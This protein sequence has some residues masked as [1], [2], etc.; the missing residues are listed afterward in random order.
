MKKLILSVI[1]LIISFW[2]A[3]Y[4]MRIYSADVLYESSQRYLAA[5]E[6][7]DALRTASLAIKKNPLEP[8]YYRG[9]AKVYIGFLADTQNRESQLLFKTA[10]LEDLKKAYKL[11]P[12]NLVTIRNSVPLYYFLAAED[13]TQPGS[14]ENI[15]EAFLSEAANFFEKTKLAFPNDVGVFTLIAKY[16]KRLGLEKQYEESKARVQQLRPDLLEWHENF[17]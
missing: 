9:R 11:N 8:N 1:I 16:E 15:D 14:K 2:S 10:A 3:Q 13:L 12:K 4:F 17:R 6:Y 5:E 7:E